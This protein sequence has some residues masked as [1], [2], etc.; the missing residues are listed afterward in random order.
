MEACCVAPSQRFLNANFPVNSL[1]F[2]VFPYFLV[3]PLTTVEGPFSISPPLTNIVVG[4]N[5]KNGK[6]WKF[7]EFTGKLENSAEKRDAE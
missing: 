4:G 5:K 7:K 1:V 6:T 2:H 3:L